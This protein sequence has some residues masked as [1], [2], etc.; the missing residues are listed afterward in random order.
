[1]KTTKSNSPASDK[2]TQ[3][4]EIVR[5]GNLT[6]KKT[7][8]IQKTCTIISL[9]LVLIGLLTFS[10]GILG[11]LLIVVGIFFACTAHMYKNIA[12]TCFENTAASKVLT[13]KPLTQQTTP[14]NSL[15]QITIATKQSSAKVETHRI[16]GTSYRQDTIKSLGT[17]NPD[18]RL[19]KEQLI[20]KN[21]LNINVY[22]YNFKSYKAELVPEP[23]NKHDS[24]AIKVIIAGKHV[25]YIKKGSCAH[26]KK[27]ISTDSIKSI[28]ATIKGGNSKYISCYDA[29]SERNKD[30]YNYSSDKFDIGVEIKIQT[31]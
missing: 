21:L 6:K 7:K 30:S 28:T 27:L 12:K 10:S 26:V 25:G 22:E 5:K 14:K 1:M 19:T 9:T 17:S 29:P 18:Y 2:R 15:P 11:I 23:T 4:E 8:S 3:Y 24:N 13:T 31:V 16:A 20:K